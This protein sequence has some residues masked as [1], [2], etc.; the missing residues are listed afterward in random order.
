MVKLATARSSRDHGGAGK[1]RKRRIANDDLAPEEWALFV[2]GWARNLLAAVDGALYICMSTKE[3]GSVSLALEELGAHWSDTIIWAKDRF[4]L[5]RADYQR[6]YE[7]I[8]F[9]WR[10][11]AKHHWCGDRNQGDVWTIARP[12]ASDVHPTTKPLA[13]VERAIENSS[14]SGDLVLDLFLGSGSTLI[15]AERTGRTCFGMELSP[16]YCDVVI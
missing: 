7:P 14:Q 15:S 11:G 2:R 16:H 4:V 9:G 1:G 10:E 12:S 8:W 13:L 6:G 3:W 5:G